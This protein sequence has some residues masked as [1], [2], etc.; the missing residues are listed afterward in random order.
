MFVTTTI[1]HGIAPGLF[2]YIFDFTRNLNTTGPA[3]P[4]SAIGG[5]TFSL[6]RD[7]C[8]WRWRRPEIDSAPLVTTIYGYRS[9][10]ISLSNDE[11]RPIFGP[12]IL[13]KTLCPPSILG[14]REAKL[15]IRLACRVDRPIWARLSPLRVQAV[16]KL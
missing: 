7:G 2:G 13:E 5:G 8:R 12:E 11:V 1:G 9:P 15:S 6:L 14:T 4:H 10:P 16:R 3:N